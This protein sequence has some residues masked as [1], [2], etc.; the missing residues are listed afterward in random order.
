MPHCTAARFMESDSP[1]LTD[2]M[3]V[4]SAPSH[5]VIH[6]PRCSE[7]MEM[8]QICASFF[9]L[10]CQGLNSLRQ[11]SGP[12]TSSSRSWMARLVT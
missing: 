1:P 12:T 3:S 9:P 10:P 6:S 8:P 2:S 11:F 7:K 5:L 4:S